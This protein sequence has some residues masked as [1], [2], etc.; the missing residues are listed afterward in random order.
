MITQDEFKA[1]AKATIE[2]GDWCP[3]EGEM[4]YMQ[5]SGLWPKDLAALRAWLAAEL[6]SARA[7]TGKPKVDR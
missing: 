2:A 6:A 1:E 5:A 4:F 3:E 7:A